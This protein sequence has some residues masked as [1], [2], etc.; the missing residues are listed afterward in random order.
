MATRDR[1]EDLF[2]LPA[3][4]EMVIDSVFDNDNSFF[5]GFIFT[6]SVF[7]VPGHFLCALVEY[8]NHKERFAAFSWIMQY[9][10]VYTSIQN[11]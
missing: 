11:R 9:E 3:A 7:V 6:A 4:V 1:A 2:R 10:R 8:R 5:L